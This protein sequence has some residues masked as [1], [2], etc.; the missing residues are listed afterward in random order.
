MIRCGSWLLYYIKWFRCFLFDFYTYRNKFY[1]LFCTQ[2]FSIITKI[3][4]E[5]NDD[6]P[7][8]LIVAFQMLSIFYYNYSLKHIISHKCEFLGLR[9]YIFKFMNFCAKLPSKG[10][11]FMSHSLFS[12]FSI[13]AI[14]I[15]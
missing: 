1:T 13:S 4:E 3:S 9:V 6:M 11:R 15:K 10:K 8:F 5:A 12:N 2:A 7:Q 14:W